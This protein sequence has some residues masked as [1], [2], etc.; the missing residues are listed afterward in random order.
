MKEFKYPMWMKSTSSDLT[1]KFHSLHGGKIIVSDGTNLNY[2][3]RIANEGEY[4]V[5]IEHTN[6]EYWIDVTDQYKD[7]VAIPSLEMCGTPKCVHDMPYDSECEECQKEA[8]EKQN[9]P[10]NIE[11][12]SHNKYKRKVPS[13]DIDV[14]DILKAF[15]VTNPALAHLVKKALVCG[16]RGHKDLKTD[17]KDIIDSSIRAYELEGFYY[18]K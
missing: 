12:K 13:M 14:Y 2:V 11:E 18:E 1:V 5:F 9:K 6:K 4:T 7:K 8:Q 15:N 3:G 10:F 16:N 17:L